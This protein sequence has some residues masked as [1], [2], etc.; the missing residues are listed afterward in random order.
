MIKKSVFENEIIAE[1]Q[2]ALQPIKKKQG[3]NGL[4][5][6]AD[7]LNSAI[8]IFE[9]AGLN[10]KADQV[11]RVL[12]KI[13]T[14]TA[15]KQMPSLQSLMDV[16]ISM[17]DLKDVSRGDMM[18]T[19]KINLALRELGVTDKE[20]VDFIGNKNYMTEQSARD[21]LDPDR[22]FNKINDWLKDPTMPVD[23][24]NLQPG[25]TIS[26]DSIPS[27]MGKRELPPG[28]DLIFKSIACDV[29]NCDEQD[30]RHKHKP[31]K[32]KFKSPTSEQMI[33]NLK[34]YGT[35]FDMSKAEDNIGDLINET[36][37]DGRN[38]PINK[39]IDEDLNKKDIDS[40]LKDKSMDR[41]NIGNLIDETLDQGSRHPIDR[42]I[43]KHINQ[44]DIEDL[45]QDKSINALVKRPKPVAFDDTFSSGSDF[46]FA[47]DLLNAEI[48]DDPLEVSEDDSE[49][50]FEDTD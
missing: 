17:Q 28:E 22:S 42:M 50:T 5:K 12:A 7:Y 25:E 38:H 43:D 20:I 40:L 24:N 18:A 4:V 9:D 14:K 44:K 32:N 13:A 1:M 27:E 2:V 29:A 37:G 34:E 6:A 39:M 26:F 49:K 35:V 30:A 46:S 41:A 47:D 31:N 23:P 16:G 21:L 45:M 36:L 11:L 15:A 33:K 48:N 8:Q 19:A 3:M 10:K